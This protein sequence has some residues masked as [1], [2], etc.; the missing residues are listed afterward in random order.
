MGTLTHGA[1]CKPRLLTRRDYPMR[2]M[3][4]LQ[5]SRHSDEDDLSTLTHEALAFVGETDGVGSKPDITSA[6][7]RDSAACADHHQYGLPVDVSR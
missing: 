6:I 4:T 1:E 7:C 2:Q 3:L 5:Q